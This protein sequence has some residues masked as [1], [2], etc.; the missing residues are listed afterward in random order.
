MSKQNYRIDPVFETAIN[1][2]NWHLINANRDQGLVTCRKKPLSSPSRTP[3]YSIFFH[4]CIR[5]SRPFQQ[6]SCPLIKRVDRMDVDEALD[7]F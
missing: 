1:R 7:K 4:R 5:S 6:F 3:R 2:E